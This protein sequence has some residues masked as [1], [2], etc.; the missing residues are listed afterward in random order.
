MHLFRALL[1]LGLALAVMPMARAGTPA[2]L[3]DHYANVHGV[4]LHYV[5]AGSGELMLFL[6][7]FPEFWYQ[8]KPQIAEFSTG[9]ET[10]APDLPGFGLSSRPKALDQYRMRAVA[11]DLRALIDHLGRKKVILVGQD[12]GGAI[13]WAFALYYPDYV[14]KLIVINAPHPA[15]F[16]RE[17]KQNP[18][19]Q[20]ASAYMLMLR[21]PNAAATLSA[22]DFKP[23]LQSVLGGE[24]NLPSYA[25]DRAAYLRNWRL[26]GGLAGGINYY[27]AAAIGPPDAAHGLAANGNYTPDLASEVVHVPTL[28][29]WGL[30]DNYLLAGNLSG[31]ERVVPGVKVDLIANGGHWLNRDNSSEVNAMIRRFVGNGRQVH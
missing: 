10:V 15:L 27:R 22:G 6:H 29:I 2:P 5:T 24:K 1:T 28:V 14:D 13:A 20:F 18:A 7:G 30:K 19:Q 9:F 8:W 16:D 25:A 17:L 23:L 12:W 26:P 31:I 11:E 4:R 3:A 21:G